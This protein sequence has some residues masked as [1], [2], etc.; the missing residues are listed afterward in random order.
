VLLRSWVFSA[1]R[2]APPLA[3]GDELPG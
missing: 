3:S 2:S 1:R